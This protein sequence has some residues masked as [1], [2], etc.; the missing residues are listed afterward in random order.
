LEWSA[1]HDLDTIAPEMHDETQSRA[2]I[3][4][5]PGQADLPSPVGRLAWRTETARSNRH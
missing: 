5:L 1:E 4:T 2:L 3:P